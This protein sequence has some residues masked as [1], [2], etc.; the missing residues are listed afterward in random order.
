MLFSTCVL[1]CVLLWMYSHLCARVYVLSYVFYDFY[2]FTYACSHVRVL[3]YARSWVA[4]FVYEATC[5]E[6]QRQ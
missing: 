6:H 4:S 5:R 1:S 3:G 2:V